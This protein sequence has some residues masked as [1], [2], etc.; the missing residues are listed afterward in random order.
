MNQ[1][2]WKHMLL[3]LKKRL[4]FVLEGTITWLFLLAFVTSTLIVLLMSEGMM[5]IKLMSE[6]PSNWIIWFF[7]LHLV[8]VVI[9]IPGLIILGNIKSITIIVPNNDEDQSDPILH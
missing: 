7:M 8:T 3:E 9:S 5:A 4:T 1:T 6:H 2:L